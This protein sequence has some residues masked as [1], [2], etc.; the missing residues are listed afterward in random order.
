MVDEDHHAVIQEVIETSAHYK[1]AHLAR[2]GAWRFLHEP[3]VAFDIPTSAHEKLQ[4]LQTP[5]FYLF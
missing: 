5:R 4:F 3:Y 2:A 1:S